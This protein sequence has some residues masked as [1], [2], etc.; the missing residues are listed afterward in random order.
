MA[1][2]WLLSIR[3]KFWRILVQNPYN[4]LKMFRTMQVRSDAA[5]GILTG[6]D[7]SVF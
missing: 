4:W 5:S 7:L 3:V 2:F 6:K 1:A